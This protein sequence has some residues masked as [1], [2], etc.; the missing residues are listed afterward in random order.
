MSSIHQ[1]VPLNSKK[2]SKKLSKRYSRYPIGTHT[3]SAGRHFA[4]VNL[5]ETGNLLCVYDCFNYDV[6]NLCIVL[7]RDNETEKGE[8]MVFV[9]LDFS[10]IKEFF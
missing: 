7:H 5:V 9:V 8:Y 10:F 2:L 1:Q 4:T 3:Q 6:Y